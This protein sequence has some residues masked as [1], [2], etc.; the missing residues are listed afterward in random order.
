MGLQKKGHGKHDLTWHVEH[1]ALEVLE[2][3]ALRRGRPG[4][5]SK[6]DPGRSPFENIIK[7]KLTS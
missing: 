4:A 1:P 5:I 7:F 6:Q 3:L 2:L